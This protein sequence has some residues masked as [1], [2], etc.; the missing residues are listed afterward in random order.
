MKSV[1]LMPIV[2][3]LILVSASFLG[4]AFSYSKESDEPQH[5]PLQYIFSK[6]K[7]IESY[8]LL[9]ITPDEFIQELQ[10]VADHKNRHGIATKMVTIHQVYDKIY[11]QGRD[12]GIQEF[13][14][15]IVQIWHH[16]C[17]RLPLHLVVYCGY[18]LWSHRD[19]VIHP[20]V[21]Q[22]S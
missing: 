18:F 4:S 1:R 20:S 2:L 11:W 17:C 22:T 13:S 8:D 9:I 19:F 16:W 21:G 12:N 7:A 15:V 5:H 3:I 6:T 14:N 10:P